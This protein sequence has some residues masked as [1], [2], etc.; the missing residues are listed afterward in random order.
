MSLYSQ[1]LVSLSRPAPM[2]LSLPAMCFFFFFLWA[3]KPQ[4]Q[5][6]FPVAA[7]FL[8]PFTCSLSFLITHFPLSDAAVWF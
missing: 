3:W 4:M 7:H 8:S 5:L 2:N 1:A 6:S